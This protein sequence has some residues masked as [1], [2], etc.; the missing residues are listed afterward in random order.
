[1][2]VNS[3]TTTRDYG[4]ISA[5]ARNAQ[6]RERLIEAGLV[7]FGDDGFAGTTIESLSSRARISTRDFYAIFKSKEELLLAVYDRVVEDAMV[8]VRAS[9]EGAQLSDRTGA[10]KAIEAALGAFARAMTDDARRARINFIVVVGVSA[11]VELKR[12]EAIH[13]FAE[14]IAAFVALLEREGLIDSAII[15]PVLYVALVGAIHETLTDWVIHTDHPPLDS[16]VRDLSLLFEAALL[17]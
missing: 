2:P 9:I 16:V 6:R 7:G 14:L 1:M 12:R 5:D 17:R 11:R 3:P 8:A 10:A 4:G 15:T 13:G